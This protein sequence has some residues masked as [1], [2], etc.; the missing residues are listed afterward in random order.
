MVHL[1]LKCPNFLPW[2]CKSNI[3]NYIDFIELNWICKSSAANRLFSNTTN[4]KGPFG[5]GR[6]RAVFPLQQQCCCSTSAT[7]SAE[8]VGQLNDAEVLE[9][10]EGISKKERLMMMTSNRGDKFGSLTNAHGWHVRRM[11]ETDEEM[12]EVARVQAEAF[13]EPVILFNDLFFQFFQAEVLAGLLYRLKNS[14]SD[15][16]ACLVAEPVNDDDGSGTEEENLVGVVDVT[17]LRDNDVLGHLPGAEEYLYVSGI[18]V[19]SKFRRQKVGTALLKACDALA[20]VWGFDYLV[21]RAY[22]DDS[23]ARN[24][25]T[26][27]GYKVVSGDPAWTIWIGRR[28]RVLMIKR[29]DRNS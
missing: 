1:P 10:E 17:V 29:C 22:E 9:A 7:S 24:L 19:L 13:H 21:L 27:A 25:Y 3:V 6:K 12:R 15:R 4:P 23:G 2:K 20:A 16:Y 18:A 28:R 26:S 8:E 14:P 11:V 5:N